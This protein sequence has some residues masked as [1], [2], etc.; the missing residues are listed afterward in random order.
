MN[1]DLLKQYI[2][3]VINEDY[4]YGGGG[5][6]DAGIDFTGGNQKQLYNIFISPFTDVF[7]TAAGETKKLSTRIQTLGKVVF[8]A[9]ISSIIPTFGSEFDKIFK[10]ESE[11]LKKI[12]QEYQ[13]V[14]DRTWAAV[15]D[16]DILSAAF[17]YDPAGLITT[18]VI[19]KSP[20]QILNLINVLTGGAF[21]QAVNKVKKVKPK[22]AAEEVTGFL[23][24]LFKT[25]AEL[26]GAGA[27]V[28][29]KKNESLI[30]EE[31]E[32]K[33]DI[34]NKINS[35]PRVK[36][37]RNSAQSV[38]R[39]GL[40]KQFDLVNGIVKA[41]NVEDVVK[42]LGKPVKGMNDLK[43][44]KEPE[45]AQVEQKILQATKQS[46][47]TMFVKKLESYLKKITDSGVP[48]SNAMVSDYKQAISRI[49]NL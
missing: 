33:P 29:G 5:Y 28:N 9:L 12:Q 27:V 35:N 1:R 18:T 44:L 10:D 34:I 32:G 14:Y 37:M 23:E 3:Q 40:E 47:K 49:R 46:V 39:K 20:V 48:E 16:N 31:K 19:R 13:D 30:R 38:V 22:S 36:R 45:R 4:D 8:Q 21:E 7:Q 11:Q 2:R 41:T 15:K 24:K 25:G 26:A 42:V 43:K 17:L 6:G